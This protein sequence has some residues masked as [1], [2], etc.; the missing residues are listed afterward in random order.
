MNVR[1]RF[2]FVFCLFFLSMPPLLQAEEVSAERAREIGQ[3]WFEHLAF[4]S[5]AGQI[6]PAVKIEAQTR[7]GHLYVLTFEGGGFVIVPDDDHTRPVLGYSRNS[8]TPD[9]SAHPALSGWLADYSELVVWASKREIKPEIKKLWATFEEEENN[10][11]RRRDTTAVEPLLST[12]W[13]QDWPYNEL[14]PVDSRALYNAMGHA[15]AGCTATAMAQVM[16]YYNYPSQG[17][18]AYGYT[19]QENPQY[20]ELTANFGGTTYQWSSMPNSI[21]FSNLPVATLIYH[22]G[23]SVDMDYGPD[24]SGAST[25]DAM[26]SLVQYFK[27][28]DSIREYSKSSFSD[29]NW[30][31][32]LK[33]ELNNNRPMIYS[34]RSTSGH[35][36]NCDGYE[37]RDYFHMNWGWGGHY[38]GYFSLDDLTPDSDSNYT[39]SQQAVVYILPETSCQCFS[40]ECCEACTYRS[41]TTVCNEQVEAEYQCGSNCGAVATVHKKVQYCSGNT[42]NCTG[43]EEWRNWETLD[44]CTAD[45]ICQT[46]GTSYAECVDCPYGCMGG[47]CC[48]CSD[49]PCCDGCHFVNASVICNENSGFEYRCDGPAC[50]GNPQLREQYQYCSGQSAQCNG[51]VGWRA[52][53]TQDSCTA[54]ATCTSDGETYARC[55]VCEQGCVDGRCRE[56]DSGPCCDGNFFLEADVACE[57]D[58]DWEYRCDSTECGAQGQSRKK[59]RFCTG[60][61][62]TCE[63]EPSWTDWAITAACTEDQ[64][65]NTDEETYVTCQTCQEGCQ[66]GVCCQCSSGVCCNGCHFRPDSVVCNDS[67]EEEFRCSGEV[68]GAEPQKRQSQQMCSGTSAT[69]DGENQWTPW[70]GIDTCNDDEFCNTD[71]ESFARCFFCEKGCVDGQCCQCT[72]GD[73]CDGC[74]YYEAD[75][76]C[77]ETEEKE[78]R[79]SGEICGSAIESRTTG[80]FCSGRSPECDGREVPLAWAVEKTC[81]STEICSLEGEEATCEIPTDGCP[82]HLQCACSDGACC[83]GCNFLEAGTVCNEDFVHSMRCGENDRSVEQKTQKRLCSGSSGKCDGTVDEGDWEVV[84]TCDT[85]ERCTTNDGLV[86][87]CEA[88][89]ESGGCRSAGNVSWGFVAFCLCFAYL[90]SRRN[91]EDRHVAE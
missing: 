60:N 8:D 7:V 81:A 69:C 68:C 21:S 49:G 72:D 38:D 76:L 59:A 11:P 5:P 45:E 88:E 52:W 28:S 78:Y 22:C 19:P 41:S 33:N 13:N 66:S 42:A 71:G 56:C 25:W 36:F 70:R 64:L 75:H 43:R 44:N 3:T 57:D 50:G 74:Q 58:L 87:R 23:I 27:Y 40:G 6:T 37:Y 9:P 90:R 82:F 84:E 62:A 12:T 89:S 91:R 17:V 35:S 10:L 18:G 4:D 83:D 39:Y 67:G 51:E 14:C 47:A 46:D 34:G 61:D 29:S 85:G 32:L 31:D 15:F 24:G 86:Y 63:A 55:E 65:C 16:K 30:K 79:C 48:E 26:Y 80:T 53:E 2:F 1:I 54:N 77:H 20:G 73:C